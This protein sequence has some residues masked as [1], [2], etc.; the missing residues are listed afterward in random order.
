MV[1]IINSRIVNVD[2]IDGGTERGAFV[3]LDGVQFNF[4]TAERDELGQLTA[5]GIDA[6]TRQ[7]MTELECAERLAQLMAV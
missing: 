3:F 5:Q 4:K 1:R 2:V 6:I 7:A